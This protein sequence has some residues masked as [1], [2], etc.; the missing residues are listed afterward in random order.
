MACKNAVAG[1]DKAAMVNLK[2]GQAISDYITQNATVMF[3]WVGVNPA[4]GA[5]DPM[6]VA[7]SNSLTG[8]I[9][10][11]PTGATSALQH[12]TIQ[13]AQIYSGLFGITVMPPSGFAIPP[14]TLLPKAPIIISPSGASDATANWISWATPIITCVLAAINPLPLPGAHA[15]FTG[16]AMMTAII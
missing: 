10:L 14:T 3:S 5:P 2:L 7:S 11:S 1:L 8:V 4:S 13:G 16:V 12:G 9:S 15:A 6:V